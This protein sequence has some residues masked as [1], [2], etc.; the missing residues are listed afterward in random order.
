M[1]L[2]AIPTGDL[3]RVSI[4][5][6]E[7]ERSCPGKITP[8]RV[9]DFPCGFPATPEVLFTRKLATRRDTMRMSFI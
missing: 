3:L 7:M 4:R 2:G 6:M 9:R 5:E 1:A 8:V